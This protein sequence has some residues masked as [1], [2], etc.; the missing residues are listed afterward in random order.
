MNTYLPFEEIGP[1]KAIEIYNHIVEVICNNELEPIR[2]HRYFYCVFKDGTEGF[3]N[4]WREVKEAHNGPFHVIGVATYTKNNK[5]YGCW[6][7]I[8][9][10]GVLR[11]FKNNIRTNKEGKVTRK[12]AEL[13]LSI[14][15]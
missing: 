4:S 2:E 10:L 12:R 1:D 3:F 13:E 8:V 15:E 14:L 7:I 5:T 6:H 11:E 9:E